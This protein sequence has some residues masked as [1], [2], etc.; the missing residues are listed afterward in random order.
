MR[1][2][3]RSLVAP[4]VAGLTAVAAAAVLVTTSTAPLAAQQGGGPQPLVVGAVA[5]PL[6]VASWLDGADPFAGGS[7][8]RPFAGKAAMLVFWAPWCGPC[9][10]KFPRLGELAAATADLPLAIVS[11]TDAAEDK[12]RA[13]LA[14]RPLATH[15]AIDDGGRTAAAYGVR[16]LPRIVL[17]AP[18][19]RIAAL[20]RH[21]QVDVAVLRR[22][23]RGEQLDLPAANQVPADVKW[24]QGDTP[25]AAARTLAHVVIEP[26]DAASGGAFVPPGAGRISADGVAFAN[27]VQLAFGA[28]PHEVQA[29]HPDYRDG[30]N[31]YRVSVKAHDGR[32]ETARA[33]LREQLERLFVF[34]AEW[35]EV[36]ERTLILRC[37]PGDV[38]AAL[39]RSVADK[40][41][42]SARGGAVDYR[43]MPM[44]RIAEA[45]GA[46]AF[47]K[48]MLDETGLDGDWDVHLEWTPGDAA[49]LDQALAAHG[50]Q[51][52]SEPRR[53]RKLLVAAR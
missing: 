15:K 5:P 47:G 2:L 16:V 53:V 26:S 38:P 21:E 37:A 35:T 22:L 24:D 42:G 27:L 8:A 28:E 14:T 50:L 52:A 29:T 32:V 43:K 19:G 20:P 9:V 40:S 41:S 6:A 39:R 10:A 25:F 51:R 33:M 31:R 4:G 3:L 44:A 12:V 48:T 30:G 7:P 34:R 49:S 18:D 17:I 11:L 23:V 1:H 13:L 46:F 45:I 36:E